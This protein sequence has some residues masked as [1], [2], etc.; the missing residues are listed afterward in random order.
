MII[1]GYGEYTRVEGNNK[2]KTISID[3]RSINARG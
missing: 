1:Y 2:K 3:M